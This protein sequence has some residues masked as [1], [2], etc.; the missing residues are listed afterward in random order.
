M[1]NMHY[2]SN[3]FSEIILNLRFWWFEVMWF[4]QIV[5]FETDYEKIE[6]KKTVMTSFQSFDF[7]W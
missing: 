6:L 7:Q 3:I 5:I 1:S 4:G 2:F